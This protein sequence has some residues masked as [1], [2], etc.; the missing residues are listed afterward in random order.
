MKINRYGYNRTD[1]GTPLV[2]DDVVDTRVGRI[3]HPIPRS[4]IGWSRPNS[5]LD[6]AVKG[7]ESNEGTYLYIL[8]LSSEE[9]ALLVESALITA[10]DDVSTRATARGIGAY[11]REALKSSGRA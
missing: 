11:I 9:L 3:G 4:G 6:F 8:S 1:D 2:D 7:F 5:Q 10:T